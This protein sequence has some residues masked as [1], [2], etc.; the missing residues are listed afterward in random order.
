MR[1]RNHVTYTAIRNGRRTT[2]ESYKTAYDV[3]TFTFSE[4]EVKSAE[5]DQDY[6]DHENV[7]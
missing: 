6:Y 3:T 1:T 4:D 7:T 5:P 2:T